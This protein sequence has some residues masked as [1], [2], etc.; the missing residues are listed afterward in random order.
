MYFYIVT[1]LSL[2]F[3]CAD[4]KN[5]NDDTIRKHSFLENYETKDPQMQK[6]LDRLKREFSNRHEDIISVHFREKERLKEKKRKEIDQLKKSYRLKLKKLKSKYPEKLKNVE[7][8]HVKP[9]DKR[10]MKHP[11][12]RLDQP[13]RNSDNNQKKTIKQSP[14]IKS[15][16]KKV[17]APKNKKREDQKT[18]PKT[19]D[20]N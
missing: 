13:D 18:K 19:L 10:N 8:K 6:E 17:T 1:L 9:L 20:R 5:I 15:S 3:I 14:K 7:K 2:S 16:S 4:S 11:D 12:P